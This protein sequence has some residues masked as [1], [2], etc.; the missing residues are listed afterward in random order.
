MSTYQLP[1]EMADVLAV[2]VGEQHAHAVLWHYD[3]TPGALEP[4]GFVQALVAAM[5][6]ADPENL[7]RLAY[8][9]PGHAA[10]VQIAK[11]HPAG[12]D[13]LRA[14]AGLSDLPS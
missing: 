7:R 4:G 6:K 1:D 12:I 9:F 5:D 8:G 13:R 3:R 10:A 2:A 14:L 11:G